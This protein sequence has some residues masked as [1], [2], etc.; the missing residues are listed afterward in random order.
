MFAAVDVAYRVAVIGPASVVGAVNGSVVYVSPRAWM[1]RSSARH[2][3]TALAGTPA[4]KAPS[5]TMPA[6]H[7]SAAR[8]H[9]GSAGE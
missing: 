6:V 5:A 2:G 8:V 7:C 9:S 4:S 1:G 3:L